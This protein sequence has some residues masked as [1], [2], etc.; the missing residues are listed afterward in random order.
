MFSLAL[1]DKVK[2]QYWV[3]DLDEKGV[4]RQL[5]SVEADNGSWI[6]KGNK[7]IGLTF[8]S[9]IFLAYVIF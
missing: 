4:P 1:P 6:L 2:G 3:T 5:V 8:V 7:K 9:P